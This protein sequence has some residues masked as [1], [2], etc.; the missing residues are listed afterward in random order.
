MF[1]FLDGDSLPSFGDLPLLG[2]SASD[3]PISRSGTSV[4][5]D[6][7]SAVMRLTDCYVRYE[8]DGRQGDMTSLQMGI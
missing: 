7:A 3:F 5:E 1:S 6:N 8:I 4:E 2:V